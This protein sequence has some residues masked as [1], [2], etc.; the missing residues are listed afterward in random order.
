MLPRTDRS[1]VLSLMCFLVF[2]SIGA[3]LQAD[4]FAPMTLNE[5]AAA[6]DAVCIAEL[7]FSK[8]ERHG[9]QIQTVF[10]FRT[11]DVLRGGV[12]TYFKLTAPGGF[13]G[14]EGSADSRL[15]ELVSRS[16]Y[17]L[18]M[19]LRGHHL[20]LLDPSQG[21][22]PFDGDD[23]SDLRAY[24]ERLPE[25]VALTAFGTEPI[26]VGLVTDTGLFETNGVRR[27]TPP[28]RGEGIQ[29]YADVST[30]PAG[31]SEAQAIEALLNALAAWEA[32]SSMIRLPRDGGVYAVRGG[33][34]QQRRKRDP[35]A[36]A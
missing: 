8:A 16:S 29:V 27:F 35:R 34:L 24:C 23:L 11:I 14:D 22:V 28:D 2:L 36:N 15:P 6:A 10:T 19:A 3:R 13:L 21:A 5:R 30:L 12:P 25:G 7:V 31:I 18:F 33:L 32:A 1:F 4:S 9:A 17:V 26:E 20:E